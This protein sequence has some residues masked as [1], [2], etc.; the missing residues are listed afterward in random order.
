MDGEVMVWDLSRDDKENAGDVRNASK[1]VGDALVGKSEV[2]DASHREPVTSVHW[3]YNPELATSSS[4]TG[5]GGYVD[6]HEL[7][8]TGGDGR[9]LVWCPGSMAR[10]VFGYELRAQR[11]RDGGAMTAWGAASASFMTSGPAPGRDKKRGYRRANRLVPRGIRRRARVPLPDPAHAR[12]DDGVPRQVYR[13][14]ERYARR[15]TRRLSKSTTDT[16]VRSTPS[17]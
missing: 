13:Q 4:S 1:T 16:P 14:R 10:P 15:C 11:G 2:S 3:S 17:P 5:T 12:D 8:S 7:V 6:G 9:V